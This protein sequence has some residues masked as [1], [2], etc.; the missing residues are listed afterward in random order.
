MQRSRVWGEPDEWLRET[1]EHWGTLTVAPLPAEPGTLVRTAIETIPGDYREFYAN[2]RDAIAGKAEL[3][4]PG[5]AGL[6]VVRLL[7]MARVSSKEERT[8]EISG[9]A[10]ALKLPSSVPRR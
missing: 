9:S 4:V 6:N 2:V 1:E 3:A 8:V 10:L 7:E 5:S